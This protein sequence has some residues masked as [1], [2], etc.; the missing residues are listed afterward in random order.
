MSQS[1]EEMKETI[2]GLIQKGLKTSEIVAQ[3]N[4]PLQ[5]IKDVKS[6]ELAKKV[7][8]DRQAVEKYEANRSKQKNAKRNAEWLAK[9]GIVDQS[10]KQ[11]EPPIIK[12]E[13]PVQAMSVSTD[14][15]GVGQEGQ[16]GP[17]SETAAG[18]QTAA[19]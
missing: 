12:N 13:A 18:E 14:A 19:N 17:E 16:A 6:E 4:Y 8:A 9:H 7:I 5:L 10:P 15:P 2:R 11:P 3:L 1:I